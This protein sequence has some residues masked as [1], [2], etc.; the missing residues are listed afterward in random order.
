[1]DIVK[2]RRVIPNIMVVT[3]V[4]NNICDRSCAYC[5]SSLHNGSN[6]NYDWNLAREFWNILIAKYNGLHVSIAGGEPSLSPHLVEAV[7]MIYDSGNTVGITTNLTRTERYFKKISPKLSYVSASYH[8]SSPDEKFLDKIQTVSELTPTTARVMMDANHWD[9]S[10]DIFEKLKSVSKLRVDPVRILDWEGGYNPHLYS[11]E[12][13]KWL[14]DVKVY[15][16]KEGHKE[17]RSE[18][19][20]VVYYNSNNQV[21]N[22]SANDLV[23]L[24][25]TNYKGWQCS[26]G[27]ESLFIKENGSIR[28]ANC[29]QGPYI[30]HLN[31]PQDIEW[32]TS[33]E[34]CD[35]SICHCVT[36]IMMT[37]SK[38]K[39][40]VV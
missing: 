24:G 31:T 7:D 38:I 3:W 32:P 4:I 28:K 15:E 1:M 18:K 14:K 37:K 27:L 20:K 33:P 5:P 8:P 29:S 17:H 36:D 25:K 11:P 13:E 23:L 12:Q 16:P 19:N 9:H 40:G 34:I 26:L 30:G 21:V 39:A 6:H 10:V 35:Q 22:T 2:V